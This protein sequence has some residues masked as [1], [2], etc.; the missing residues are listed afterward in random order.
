[1]L[2]TVRERKDLVYLCQILAVYWG[3]PSPFHLPAHLSPKYIV[4]T[5]GSIPIELLQV[6]KLCVKSRYFPFHIFYCWTCHRHQFDL[7]FNSSGLPEVPNMLQLE[8]ES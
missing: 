6:A 1:M 8:I 7:R 4:L 5:P 3:H 2:G